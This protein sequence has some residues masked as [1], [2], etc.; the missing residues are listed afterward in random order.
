M[1]FICTVLEVAYGVLSETDL[2]RWNLT[3]IYVFLSASIVF[4][5][6]NFCFYLLY[7]TIYVPSYRAIYLFILCFIATIRLIVVVCLFLS[8]LR[9]CCVI[10]TS[11]F[12]TFT[13]ECL[14]T[15]YFP[16]KVT[17]RTYKNTTE[18]TKSS[19]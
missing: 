8:S 4:S 1:S 15:S 7:I 18:T 3:Q 17:R 10:F 2:F 9:M 11:F 12:I 6:A 16:P 13:C 14:S 5:V 19:Q